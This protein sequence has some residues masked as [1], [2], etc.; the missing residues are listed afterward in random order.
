VLIDKFAFACSLK[1]IFIIQRRSSSR[2]W[3]RLQHSQDKQD[4]AETNA[5]Y[6]ERPVEVQLQGLFAVFI[7]H[8]DLGVY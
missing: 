6:G 1:V 8:L 4:V 3:S 7:K 5:F 2:S